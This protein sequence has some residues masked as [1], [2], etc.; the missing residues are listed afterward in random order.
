MKKW[1]CAVLVFSASL[2]RGDTLVVPNKY[3]NV[4]AP[5]E[6]GLFS[7]GQTQYQEVFDASTFL[8]IPNGGILITGF[9][10]RPDNSGQGR[11]GFDL[12]LPSAEVI[13]STTSR[14]STSLSPV[15]DNNVGSDE[16]LVRAAT[17]LHISGAFPRDQP[18]PF[19]ITFSFDKPFRYDP[20]KGSLLLELHIT[21][22]VGVPHFD[23]SNPLEGEGVGLVAGSNPANPALLYAPVTQF[24]YAVPEP[25]IWQLGIYAAAALFLKRRL[26]H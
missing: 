17:P 23:F 20:A 22:D 15:F 6:G 13:A 21:T 14:T 9:S 26:S 7:G 19:S 3:A 4:D 18:S 2:S 24:T 10:W 5:G 25:E 16:T 1:T 8:N 12:T 11:N